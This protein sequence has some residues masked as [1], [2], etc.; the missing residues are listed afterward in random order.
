METPTLAVIVTL[1][2]QT[3]ALGFFGGKLWQVTHQNVDAIK[4]LRKWKHDHVTHRLFQV[5]ELWDTFKQKEA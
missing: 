3:L 5:D 2:L 1:L 4:E